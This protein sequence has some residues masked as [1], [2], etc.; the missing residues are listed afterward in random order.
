MSFSNFL[1][2]ALDRKHHCAGVRAYY[3]GIK[4]MHEKNYI[5]L[6]FLK[7]V[8][9]GYF[10][11]FPLPE[12]KANIGLGILSKDVSEKKI[13]LKITIEHRSGQRWADLM[14]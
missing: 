10:W 2:E 13:D 9:P 3:S 12:G 7:E 6:H 8:S 14:A 1:D 5:E 11:I 4:G